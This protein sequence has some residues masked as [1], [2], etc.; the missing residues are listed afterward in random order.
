M[1]AVFPGVGAISVLLSGWLSDR[2]GENGRSTIMFFGFVASGA[3]LLILTGLHSTPG[4][5]ILAVGAIGLVAL[6]LLGPYSYL[7]G[8]YALDFGGKQGGGGSLGYHRRSRLPGRRSC[9]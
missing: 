1:S 5:S 4:G 7:G 6:C 9:G 2:I 8:A 3:A